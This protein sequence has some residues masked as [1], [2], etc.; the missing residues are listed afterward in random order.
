MN[1]TIKHAKA[2]Q[3]NIDMIIVEENI[4]LI[5]EDNGIG[6]S[7]RGDEKGIG[8]RNI[9]SRVAFLEGEV[10][11]DYNRQGTTV[12]IVIPLKKYKTDE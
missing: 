7:E 9:H 5:Y 2:S 11:T 10:N 6:F 4:T 3:A 1:N 8:I 12:I